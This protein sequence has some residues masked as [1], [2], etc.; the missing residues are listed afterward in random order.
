M[1]KVVSI[2]FFLPFSFLFHLLSHPCHYCFLCLSYLWT[3]NDVLEFLLTLFCIQRS[4]PIILLVN[5]HC[6]FHLLLLLSFT[7]QPCQYCNTKM[8]ETPTTKR[9]T[10]TWETIWKAIINSSHLLYVRIRA[11]A[12]TR[13]PASCSI[14]IQIFFS[15]LHILLCLPFPYFII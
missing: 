10:T 9:T 14:F 4:T 6:H 5:L 12:D 2:E 15:F 13:L 8:V 3:K 11:C 1:R 7:K